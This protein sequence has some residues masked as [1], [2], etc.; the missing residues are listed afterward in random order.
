MIVIVIVVMI[1]IMIVVMIMIMI[2]IVIMII[3]LTPHPS[4]QCKI[5]SSIIRLLILPTKLRLFIFTTIIVILL[6]YNYVSPNPACQL[7]LWEETGGRG[8]NP[9]LS[10]E[11]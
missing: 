2:M 7:S 3:Q 9:R 4:F 8:E 11:R 5:T 1:M 6:S 10:A